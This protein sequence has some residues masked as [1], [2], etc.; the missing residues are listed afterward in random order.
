M[1][2]DDVR[3]AQPGRDLGLAEEAP[4]HVLELGGVD[5]R[6]E[7]DPLYRDVAAEQPVVGAVDLAEGAGAEPLAHLVALA[8][9]A[10]ESRPAR[11]LEE[12]LQLPQMLVLLRPAATSAP[13]TA[14]VRRS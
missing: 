7:S 3:V 12:S 5:E 11:R 2:R 10:G 13:A 9:D 14:E 4:L 1:G 6:L 8:E